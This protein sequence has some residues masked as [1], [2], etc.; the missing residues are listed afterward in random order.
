MRQS[1]LLFRAGMRNNQAY[2][3]QMEL[4]ALTGQS[5]LM[6]LGGSRQNLDYNRAYPDKGR[7]WHTRTTANSAN[8][9][10]SW[11]STAH[12]LSGSAEFF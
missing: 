10:H 6:W 7:K 9:S 1:I 5:S 4:K 12:R 2:I 11:Y 3:S 8:N